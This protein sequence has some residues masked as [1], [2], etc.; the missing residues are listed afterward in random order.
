MSWIILLIFAIAGGLF[1]IHNFFP[2]LALICIPTASISAGILMAETTG[3]IVPGVILG[4]LM[5]CGGFIHL[6][7]YDDD[8][9]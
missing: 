6:I 3:D 8:C 1:A 5:I 9:Y 7:T 2:L 4:I